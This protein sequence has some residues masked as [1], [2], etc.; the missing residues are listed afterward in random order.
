[1]VRIGVHIDQPGPL[2]QATARGADA[3]Q[4]FCGDPQGWRA[5]VTSG[6]PDE[7]RAAFTAADVAAY[8]HAPYVVNVATT[9]N[10]IRIPSRKILTQQLQAAASIGARGLIVHGGHVNNGVDPAEGYANW[11]KVMERVERPITPLIENTAGGTNAMARTLDAI[12]RLW[13]AVTAGISGG[14]GDGQVGFCLD[15]C[16]ANSGGLDLADVVAQIKGSPRPAD[17]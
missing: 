12:G 3:V 15:T 4:F 14:E 11:Q 9:N 5:P 7:I 8:I 6:V 1:M 17:L 2:E 13:D 10:R 16:H